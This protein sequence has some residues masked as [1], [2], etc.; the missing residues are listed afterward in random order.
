MRSEWAPY[1]AAQRRRKGPKGGSQGC[2]PVGCQS[3]DGLSDNPGAAA[4]SQGRM[5]GDRCIGVAFLLVTSL[6]VGLLP[7]AL[8]AG[9][10]ILAA[11]AAQWPRKE[12]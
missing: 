6:Y 1:A 9:C 10:A 3:S 8:R 7:S 11:P 5:P 12:K 4:Q 2:E